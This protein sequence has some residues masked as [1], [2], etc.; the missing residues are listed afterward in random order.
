MSAA[1]TPQR[2][3]QDAFE[4]ALRAHGSTRPQ[5]EEVPPGIERVRKGLSM[6]VLDRVVDR[7]DLEQAALED[8][9]GISVR[10]LQRRRKQGKDLTPTESDRLWR[11]LHIW[12]RT[13]AAFASNETARIWLKTPHGLLGGETPLERLDTEPGLREV[14]DLLTTIHE[15]N[16]A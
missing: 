10:T 14:E 16:A 2:T 15:T 11:L 13:Q 3:E 7:L 8:V 5:A 1:S 12:R 9:L 6:T 4:E